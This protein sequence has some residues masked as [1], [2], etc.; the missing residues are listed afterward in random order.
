MQEPDSPGDVAAL[1][2][3]QPHSMPDMRAFL[4]L[5]CFLT[6]LLPLLGPDLFS[7]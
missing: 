1:A 4:S 6:D 5:S 7:R 2:G 3:L